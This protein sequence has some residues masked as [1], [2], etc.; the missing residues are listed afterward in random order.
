MSEYGLFAQ[1]IGLIGL[2]SLLSSLSA[3]VMLPVL[4]KNMPLSDF[5][6]WTQVNVT[7]GLVSTLMLLGLPD[8]LTRF[9]SA[10]KNREE[11]QE[12]FWTIFIMILVWGSAIVLL[13]SYFSGTLA[14][15]LFHGDLSVAR[16]VPII[17]L[18]HSLN[19]LL[20][21]FFRT[22]Q[23]MKRYSF[24]SFLTLVLDLALI[25]A[26]VLTGHGIFGA[27]LALLIS[28]TLLFS[29]MFCLIVSSI[30]LR[31]PEF[32]DIRAYLAFGLP[33]VPSI[34]SSW[35]VNSSDRFVINILLGTAAVAVY[36]PGYILGNIIGMFAG[37]LMLVLP[38]DLSK[39]YDRDRR[40]MVETMLNRSL[41]YYLAL[42]IP[43]FF[44]LSLLSKPILSVLSTEEIAS[45]GYLI[46]PFIA[47]SMILYGITTI[48]S[49]VLSLQKKTSQIG[50][51][52]MG[53]ALLN[54]IATVALVHFLGVIG[55]AIATLVAFA[56]VFLL[57][58]FLSSRYTK[59]RVDRVF[60]IKSL[61][62][63]LLM[64]GVILAWLPSTF[65][66]IFAEI[67]VCVIVYFGTLGILGGF[68]ETEIEFLKNTIFKKY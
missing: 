22:V 43:S 21:Y 42:A 57:M 30:G 56:F 18:V 25:S 59:L 35:V 3:M 33:I 28:R 65:V 50:L 51:I 44:G 40:D 38:V 48:L 39:H 12:R 63:S 16:I 34:F 19:I 23:Q 26:L 58:A 6:I 41:K 9:A 67:G 14:G 7:M 60:L 10:A 11:V 2:V 46:T 54:L 15:I 17:V 24:F 5:G 49:N 27:V 62:A 29:I 8:A 52:W 37:P 13:F 32:K 64:S 4:T 1:R 36:S 61:A 47:A 68:E 53:A 45:Q 31:M 66:E 20:T 55:G